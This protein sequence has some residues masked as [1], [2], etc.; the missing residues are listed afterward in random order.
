MLGAG[1]VRRDCLNEYGVLKVF[2]KVVL[3]VWSDKSI[4][5]PDRVGSCTIL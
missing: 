4:L 5:K 2:L 3:K 1:G